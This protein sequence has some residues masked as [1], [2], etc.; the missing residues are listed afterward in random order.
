M[1]TAYDDWQATFTPFDLALAWGKLGVPLVDRW[2]EWR[3]ADRWYFYHF[4]QAPLGEPSPADYVRDHSANV[5]VIPATPEVE[6]AV[7][8]LK[9]DDIVFLEGMLV[10]VEAIVAEQ[11]L[12]FPTSLSR[13]DTG[14]NSCEIFYVE[15]ILVNFSA[16]FPSPFV[17]PLP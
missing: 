1:L 12:S 14:A 11:A 10:D 6:E 17:L 15:R 16:P 13:T 7:R 4:Y 5:H 3:Q 9:P 8:Q 2:I